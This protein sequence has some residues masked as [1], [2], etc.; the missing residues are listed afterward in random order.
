MMCFPILTL[1]LYAVSLNDINI[2]FAL[3]NG[4]YPWALFATPASLFFF[5]GVVFF[6]GLALFVLSYFTGKILRTLRREPLFKI[7]KKTAKS[8]KE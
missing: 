6:V 1:I 2:K 3:S 8:I 5:A 7:H 4:G